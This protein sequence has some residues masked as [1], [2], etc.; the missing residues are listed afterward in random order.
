MAGSAAALAAR[1]KNL[2][3][4]IFMTVPKRCRA[5][6]RGRTIVNNEAG[7]PAD[8]TSAAYCNVRDFGTPRW[9]LSNENYS[10][11][12]SARKGRDVSSW[13]MLPMAQCRFGRTDVDRQVTTSGSPTTLKLPPGKFEDCFFGS[14]ASI[15]RSSSIRRAKSN[16][17]P[18]IHSLPGHDDLRLPTRRCAR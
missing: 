17:L 6:A 14:S 3:R 9:Q 2:R 8:S 1:Y 18:S 12:R 10:D 16:A 11:C 4:G 15:P 5:S 7:K 13:R